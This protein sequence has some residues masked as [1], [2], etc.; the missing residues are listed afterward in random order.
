MVSCGV[1]LSEVAVVEIRKPQ[2]MRH[3]HTRGKRCPMNYQDRYKSPPILLGTPAILL[4]ALPER[5]LSGASEAILYKQDGYK[6]EVI[7]PQFKWGSAVNLNKY[8][9]IFLQRDAQGGSRRN[10]RNQHTG[11]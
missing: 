9:S 11:G 10:P 6:R 5:C 8:V 7:C 4:S 1:R 3:S 2:V